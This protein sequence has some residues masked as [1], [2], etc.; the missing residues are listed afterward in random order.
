LQSIRLYRA[1]EVPQRNANNVMC[2]VIEVT[3]RE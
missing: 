1:W 3:T 2:G